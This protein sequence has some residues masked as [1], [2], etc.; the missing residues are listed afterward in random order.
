MSITGAPRYLASFLNGARLIYQASPL[1]AA[2]FFLVLVLQALV[3]GLTVFAVGRL[4]DAA[5]AWETPAL[6]FWAGVWLAIL[7]ADQILG[8]VAA[9]LQGNLNERLTAFFNEQLMRKIATFEDLTPFED[10]AFYNRVQLL[11][12]Q[13][14]YQPTNLIIF[15]AATFRGFVTLIPLLF[16]MATVLWWVP[17]ALVVAAV[18]YALVSFKLQRAVWETLAQTNPEARRMDYA[19]RLLL[20]PAYAKEHRLYRSFEFWIGYYRRHF[21]RLHREMRAA[22]FRQLRGNLAYV[23]V[24]ALGIAAAL[25]GMLAR[26]SSAGELAMFLQT[27]SYLQN[28]LLMLISDG[29]MLY[30]SLLYLDEAR[31]F[32]EEAP[33]IR[34]GGRVV[35]LEHPPRIAFENV[36]FVYPDGRRALTGIAFTIEPGETIGLVGENGAGKTT[37]V[38]LLLRFYDPTEGRILVDGVDLRELDVEAWRRQIAAVFQDY[39]RYALTVRENVTLADPPRLAD[40]EGARRAIEAAGAGDLLEKLPEGLE[41]PLS[42]MFGGTDLSTGE[43]QK[44]AI[45]RAFFRESAKVMVLDEPTASLDPIQEVAVFER[46]IELGEGRTVLV[47][48]H[49]L[50]S[51]RRADR[52]AVLEG[53]RL[54]ELGSHDE[55]LRLGGLYARMYAAQS[56]WYR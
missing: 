49:R 3:P 23:L 33:G 51:V 38:K 20:D 42:K 15:F 14:S 26:R 5:V 55:L 52:I 11:R 1:L 45:A 4:V 19:G 46:F 7:V 50:G 13:A 18:P 28:T 17:L 21:A 40:A 24:S 47:V 36:G 34:P 44:L 32:L 39:G 9:A 8:P 48:S 25:L 53:G 27:L 29:S 31:A 43:W 10:E 41:T 30:E 22:R 16:A 2:G 12:E 37:L 56:E 6:R 54:R 35:I